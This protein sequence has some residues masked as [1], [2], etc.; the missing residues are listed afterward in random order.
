M[1]EESL[2]KRIGRYLNGV[3]FA[4]LAHLIMIVP[5]Q[6]MTYTDTGDYGFLIPL[7]CGVLCFCLYFVVRWVSGGNRWLFGGITWLSMAL[8]SLLLLLCMILAGISFWQCLAYALYFA[9]SEVVIT[10]AVL[11]EA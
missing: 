10:V 1:K 7:S 4:L 8:F 2:M 3:V 11:G 5:M 9:I 6:L